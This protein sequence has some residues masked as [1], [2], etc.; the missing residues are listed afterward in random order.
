[1][2]GPFLAC[3]LL[4]AACGDNHQSNRP[5][6][7]DSFELTTPEDLPVM[8]TLA[9]SDPD[10]DVVTIALRDQPANGTLAITNFTITYTPDADYHG[11]DLFTLVVSDGT[12]EVVAAVGVTVTPVND[13]PVGGP[14]VI[15]AIED[16]PRVVSHA[17]LLANDTDVDG[18]PL[19]I[20]AVSDP[21]NG[22]VA[23]AGTDV[24]FT[25]DPDFVGTGS[26]V[27][28]LSDGAAS[29]DVAVTVEVGGVNDPPVAG[30]D[31][32]TTEE[33][34][35]ITL[36]SLLANDTDVDGQTLE[37]V[38]VANAV[39]GTAT[40]VDATTVL[41]TPDP[42][43]FGIATFDY[44]VSDGVDSDVGLVTITVT[45]VNDAPIA[46]D[47]TAATDEDTAVELADLVANDIDVD[48]PALAVVAVGNEV[49]GT[50]TLAGGVVTFT[51]D[52]D[53]H[54]IATFEYTV[55]DGDLT[56]VGLVTVTV[57]PVNDP[58]IAVD[59]SGTTPEDTAIVFD[60]LVA[61][62]IDVDSP[63]LT[64]VAV[65]N[66]VNG[67]VELNGG[68][69]RFTPAPDFNGTATF[70][71]TVSDGELTDVGLVTIT[72]TPVNDPPVAGDDTVAMQADTSIDIPHATLLANDDDGG[73]GG[74]LTITAVQNAQN[75][76]AILNA[77]TITFTPDAG[78][79]GEASFDYVVSDGTD[80]DVGRVTVT[81][82]AGAVCGDGVISAPEACDDGN[83]DAGDGCSASCTIELGFTCTGEPSVCT[84]IC[85]DGEVVGDEQCDDANEDE[86]DG[87]TTQCVT[88]VVC[89]AAEIPGGTAY[90]VDPETG[91][92]FVAFAGDTT[93]AAAQAACVDVGGYLA[94]VTSA[95]ES[96][97]VTSVVGPGQSPWLGATD[98]EVDDDD[99]FVWVTGEP[100]TFKNFAPGEPDDDA[101][102]GG[103]GEC[104]HVV[105][106]SGQWADTNCTFVG[107][108]VGR[109]CE[110]QPEPC[111]DGIVQPFAGEE[112]DDGNTS[113]LDGCSATCQLE[114]GC[115]NGVIDPGEECDDD[116][117]EDGDGC[118]ATCQLEVGC[119]NGIVDPGEQ[120]DDDN[121][122]DGDGCSA[123]CTFENLVR[124]T[125][126]GSAGN[127]ATFPADL[128]APGIS[129]I[130]EMS[131][132]PGVT[133]TAAGNAFSA[134]GWTQLSA[135]DEA[136][137]FS[138]TIAPEPGFAMTL[139]ILELDERRSNTGIRQWSVRSSLDGFLTDLQTFTVPDN[140]L[141]R[142]DQRVVL[143]AAFANLTTA[144]ELR[145]FGFEA[146]AAG[147]TWRIDNV[148]LFGFTT[149]P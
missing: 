38:A 35:P 102:F 120:C 133:P 60:D 80:T 106:D 108:V 48:G 124:F 6:V 41:F 46:V 13:P 117:L 128:V 24:I 113:D 98:D 5:P 135:I 114:V 138:L 81:V 112:C 65:A 31:T 19:A 56:D 75:G 137:Y 39:N 91:H 12:D 3:F 74:P 14:D 136:D 110:L 141:T 2:R 43:F 79:A 16:T 101:I 125:F 8:V 27:Y 82:S 130:P 107:H 57:A 33:D 53:F 66:P 59:D 17:A 40:L 4:L 126:T 20:T 121:L 105:D 90:A 63:I 64:V 21:V 47:D 100:F 42:D 78:F 99:V 36:T 92:C 9:P 49:N 139:Q 70:E 149:A 142:L 93:F 50:A 94:T 44:T 58:P 97:V 148:E 25:P 23:I 71:Y 127:E 73:D 111:G 72:V 103:V 116:N 119:G 52:P 96:A 122:V 109:I 77:S 84:A 147:G 10:G 68:S 132:G 87:C 55:S 95:G 88:G 45:P 123:T 54:G 89:T 61:N 34:T 144:V 143:P 131:R 62:D 67:S 86:T 15:A 1:M 129:G 11:T 115:G 18:D 7:L 76:T 30:D 118:S 83:T 29:V 28:T 145:I 140:D 104:L 32:A 22:G 51:P 37:I 26:F 69:P 146:E 85:G 134:S